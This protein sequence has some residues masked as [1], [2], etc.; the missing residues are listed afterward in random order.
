[1]VDE[2]QRHRHR[3]QTSNAMDNYYG[4]GRGLDVRNPVDWRIQQAHNNP[5][6]RQPLLN[7]PPVAG[8]PPHPNPRMRGNMRHARTPNF[9]PPMREGIGSL[10]KRGISEIWN[11]NTPTSDEIWNSNT[12]TSDEIWNSNTP[13]SNEIM[14]YMEQTETAGLWQTWQKIK[15]RV[16]EDAANDWLASQQPAYV[17]RG[18]LMSLRR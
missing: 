16:G 6:N 17:N 2:I 12:P 4:F 7:Q 13:T 10:P 9:R 15:D 8:P 11:S 18:G 5:S 14:P 3:P 1:M